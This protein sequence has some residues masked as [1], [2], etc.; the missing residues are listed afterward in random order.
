MPDEYWLGQVVRV[1]AL[2]TD[3]AAA[4]VPTDDAAEELVAYRQD[5]SLGTISA[6]SHPSTGTY[7]AE[8]NADQ[9]GHWEVN[10]GKGGVYRFYVKPIRQAP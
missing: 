2:L 5:G 1:T 7:T 9:V 6:T 10:D 4:E 8:V 3:P